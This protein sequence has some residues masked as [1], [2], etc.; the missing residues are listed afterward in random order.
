MLLVAVAACALLWGSSRVVAQTAPAAPT[1][2]TVTATTNTLTVTWSAPADTGGS[3]IGAYDVRYIESDTADADKLIDANWT[4]VEAWSAGALSYTVTGLHDGT[5]YDVQVRAENA[6]EEGAWSGTR[7]VPTT[8]HADTR[9]AGTLVTLGTAVAGRI[10]SDSDSDYFRIVLTA[11]TD[12]WTYTTGDVDTTG[13]VYSSGGVLLQENEDGFL[14]ENLGNFSMRSRLPAG[15]YYLRVYT[16]TGASPG[17]YTLHT[18]VVTD[19]GN[20]LATATE[21]T[22]DSITPGLVGPYSASGDEDVFKIVLTETTDFWVMLLGDLQVV[23][24]LLDSG[25]DVIARSYQ[26]FSYS[27]LLITTGFNN[28]DTGAQERTITPRYVLHQV[29]MFL[30]LVG[31]RPYTMVIRTGSDP[32]VRRRLRCHSRC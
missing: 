9:T 5:G 10:S 8:D 23:A 26:G 19:P 14:D 28:R 29:E 13:E 11:D 24:Y 21:V 32:G 17:R 6:T 31:I 15:T 7:T 2:V 12:L 20:S 1:N 4:L 30:S 25:G 3:A 16:G 18:Q 22:V 27:Y